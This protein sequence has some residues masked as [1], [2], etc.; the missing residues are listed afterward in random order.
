MYRIRKVLN[1]NAAIVIGMEDNG[2]YLLM[3]KGVG[4]GKKTGERVE[5]GSE[6]TAY[7]LQQLTDRGD[8]GEN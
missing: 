2:E 8:E 6:T 1:H 5:A 4:F 3:G 7:C